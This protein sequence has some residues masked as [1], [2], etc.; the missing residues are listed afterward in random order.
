MTD[1]TLHSFMESGNA[2]KAALMLELSGADW[3]PVWVDFFNGETRTLEFRALN[4]MGEVPVLVDHTTR[5]ENDENLT[6]SQSGVIL[7]HLCERFT[8]FAPRDKLEDREVLRWLLFDNQKLTGMV[9][10][11]RFLTHFKG[12]ENEATEFLRG[13]MMGALKVLE[14]HLADREWVAADRCTIADISLWFLKR[15]GI[16]VAIAACGNYLSGAATPLVMS[17]FIAAGGWRYAYDAIA[18]ITLVQLR[19]FRRGGTAV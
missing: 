4:V 13:R 1:Y 16:A 3:R 2:Y 9:G 11:Y 15:R 6:L 7:Y 19:F 12:M 10:P 14:T 8:D 18:V 5:D 17:G